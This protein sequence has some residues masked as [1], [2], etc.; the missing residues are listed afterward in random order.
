MES[1]SWTV[2]EGRVTKVVSG[3]SIIV[4]TKLGPKKVKLVCL[5]EPPIGTPANIAAKKLLTTLVQGKK[6]EIW[7]NNHPE[8]ISQHV[9]GVLYL[10]ELGMLDV[11]LVLI[12]SGLASIAPSPA[13]SVSAHTKCHLQRAEIEARQA[14]RGLYGSPTDHPARQP[15]PSLKQT[16]QKPRVAEL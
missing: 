9:L 12:H 5:S 7:H 16:R 6:V 13:Y 1:M 4:H 3:D 14:R 11:N 15:N 2:L 10:R 8:E